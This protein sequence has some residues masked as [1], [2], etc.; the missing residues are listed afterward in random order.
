MDRVRFAVLPLTLFMTTA[1]SAAS[2]QNNDLDTINVVSDNYSPQAE[3][4]TTK[5][6]VKVRQATKMS[7]VLRGVPGVN[8]NGARSIVERYNIRGV[9]EEYLSITVDGAR[10]EGYSFH[11]AG[12]YGIDPEILKRVDIDVGANSVATG[13]GSLG[14]SIKFETVDAADL[15]EQDRD[16]GAKLK[17]GWGSNGNSNQAAATL[18]GRA[19]NFDLLGYFNY[20]HQDNGKDGNGLENKNKGHLQNYLFKVKYNLGEDHWLKLSA[21]HYT[22][23]SVNCFRANFDYCLGDV[24]Q[25]GEKGY[26]QTN[27]ATAVSTIER[28]TYTLG[29]AYNP[30]NNP[31]LNLKANAYST[32]TENTSMDRKQSKVKTY[33]GSI[34]NRSDFDLGPSTHSLLVGGEYYKTTA[35]RYGGQERRST[36]IRPDY[37]QHAYS[38]SLYL[39]DAI[40]L[41]DLIITPRIRFD[42]YRA[43]LLDLDKSYHRFSK[44]LGLKYSLTDNLVAFAN[45]TELF[46][47]PGFGEITL[48][49]PGRYNG[50]LA[51]TRGDNKEIG[52][53][54]AKDE[55]FTAADGF[56]ITAKYFHTDYDNVNQSITDP[57]GGGSIYASLGKVK[58]TGVEAQARYYINN[59]G[60]SLSYARARSEKASDG[61]SAFPDTGDRYTFGLNYRM[62][63]INVEMGWNT[64]WVRGLAYQTTQSSIVNKEEYAVSNAYI[65]WSPAQVKG[66]ELSFGIDN[67]FNR[68]YKDHSTQY[69]GAV[70]LD[71]GRNYKLTLSYKF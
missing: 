49:A 13:A 69:Y 51:P 66:L 7:D 5:G 9:S 54:Y 39:E 60:A 20:R 26:V 67:L 33:G 64:M 32:E 65:S 23:T 59:F 44:A 31:W 57:K 61:F 37:T 38:T 70:D 30:Q 48:V 68:A 17:Y 16:F 42:H 21:E 27:H 71:P 11:H 12:N 46:K 41:G 14:G 55:I 15:L 47:G 63:E 4:V 8:V 53:S 2:V 58:L 1:I 19:G 36:A 24:P 35:L 10:Q 28:T 6:S 43:D 22:N 52:F 3:N 25:P 45:Y 29:Y 40:G 62:P 34:S 50:S 56:S 18:Y